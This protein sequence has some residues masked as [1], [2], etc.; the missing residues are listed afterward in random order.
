MNLRD[1]KAGNLANIV[2]ELSMAKSTA[3]IPVKDFEE[4]E[5]LQ[6]ITGYQRN[7]HYAFT[8]YLNA[9]SKS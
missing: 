8:R 4:K 5:I 3:N 9:Y 1:F 7:K 6:E 2:E